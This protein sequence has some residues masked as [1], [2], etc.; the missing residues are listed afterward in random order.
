MSRIRALL[1]LVAL[2]LAAALGY[3]AYL[4]RP[5]SRPPLTASGTIEAE[6]IA[7]AAELGGR[8]ARL[9]VEAGQTVKQDQVL[10][11]LDDALL[12]AQHRQAQAALQ[13][14][15]TQVDLAQ[16]QLRVAEAQYDLA[17]QQA[18][19]A[20]QEARLQ[21]WFTDPP[22]AFNLPLWYFTHQEAL[23]AAQA[24]VERAAQARQEALDNLAH[25]QNT[26]IA[27]DLRAAESRL[28]QARAEFLAAQAMLDRAQA[29]RDAALKEQ[30]QQRLDAARNALE[31]AQADYDRLLTQQQAQDLLEARAQAAVAQENYD[32]ALDRWYALQWGDAAPQVRLAEAQLQQAQAA[33]Q[34]AQAAVEQ[35]Q[36]N[37]NSIEVQMEKTVVRA[38]ADGVVMALNL[39]AGEVVQP[40]VPVLTLGQLDR[41]TITVYI[42]EDRL[43][44]LQVGQ[45][46]RLT[47]DAFP[48]ETFSAV[49]TRIADRA[50]YTP[51]N[52]QTVEGRKTM[53]FAVELRI[54][55]PSGR[56]KPGMPADVS[57]EE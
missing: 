51:R 12:Q 45:R 28:A 20:A 8:V 10:F 53:V 9:A 21:A 4:S 6:E 5:Q 36:A 31:A 7:V 30:A 33:L 56:L 16:A 52:V 13:A 57:F 48:H 19:Q 49:V 18:H 3:L 40:G 55:D 1:L 50:E 24:A 46:A 15:Q 43:G 14:A 38:P 26:L 54:E 34:Q 29:Q 2:V 32:A 39:R 11:A 27:G 37:L 25:L 47:V 35:A 41:L 42:P 23:D 17:R 22:N 44:D